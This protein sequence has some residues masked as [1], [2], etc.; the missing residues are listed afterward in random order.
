MIREKYVKK[1]I[2]LMPDYQCYPLWEYDEFGLVANLNPKDL[3]I[4]EILIDKFILWSDMYDES[5]CLD[6]P[7]NSAFKSIQHEKKFKLLGE[8]LFKSLSKELSNQYKIIYE[9]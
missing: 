2:K 8:E 3:P 5:L 7:I 6:D 9:L 4:S 1:L